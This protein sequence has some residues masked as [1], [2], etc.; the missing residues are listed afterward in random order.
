MS[1][2]IFEVV[3]TARKS[4]GLTLKEVSKETGISVGHLSEY[5][6][7][8]TNLEGG[9]LVSLCRML[10]V[11]LG[12]EVEQKPKRPSLEETAAALGI[13]KEVLNSVFYRL[14]KENQ[15]KH[16][17]LMLEDLPPLDGDD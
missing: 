12:G 17:K 11:P 9:K 8:K 5:E 14:S 2:N 13:K 6:N 10:G 1:K 15:E 16:L 4:R 7:G 3:K